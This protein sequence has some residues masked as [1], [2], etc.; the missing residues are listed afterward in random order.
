MKPAFLILET[1]AENLTQTQSMV[2]TIRSTIL[3][4]IADIQIIFF[5]HQLVI[6]TEFHDLRFKNLDFFTMN[7]FFS[8]G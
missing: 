2:F 1:V 7:I 4:Q 5:T 6:L 8:L 3:L